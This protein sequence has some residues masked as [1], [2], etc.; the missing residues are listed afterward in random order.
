ML[1]YANYLFIPLPYTIPLPLAGERDV[2]FWR[3]GVRCF[4]SKLFLLI[5][6][7]FCFLFYFVAFHDYHRAARDFLH[8]PLYLVPGIT[9]LK[10]G[11]EREAS[12]ALHVNHTD[13]DAVFLLALQYYRLC[14]A[15]IDIFPV[16]GRGNTPVDRLVQDAIK[17]LVPDLV[18]VETQQTFF[19]LALVD[20]NHD[21]C[22]QIIFP[23]LEDWSPFNIAFAVTTKTSR[24]CP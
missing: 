13:C 22:Q 4:I 18:A 5:S 6:V 21:V 10:V 1:F 3:Y 14:G 16:F 11:G 23:V 7:Y 9:A 17:F 12:I 15:D 24:A 19:V 2:S 20:G 8:F